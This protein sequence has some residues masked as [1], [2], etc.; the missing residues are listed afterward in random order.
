MNLSTHSLNIAL[1]SNESK[2]LE[3]VS[4]VG[5]NWQAHMVTG[6]LVNDT[7]ICDS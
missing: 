5:G 4:S 2:N 3:F 7:Y 6:K 1:T